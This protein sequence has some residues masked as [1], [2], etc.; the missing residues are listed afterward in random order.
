MNDCPTFEF[1]EQDLSSFSLLKASRYCIAFQ[2][3]F[4][5]FEFIFSISIGPFLVARALLAYCLLF[6]HFP[7]FK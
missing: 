3:S 7:P 6:V 5:S 2:L 4:D 1:F